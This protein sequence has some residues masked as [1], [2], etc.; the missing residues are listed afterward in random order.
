MSEAIRRQA[1]WRPG[2]YFQRDSD[3]LGVRVVR[4]AI[5]TEND[6]S[7]ITGIVA[8]QA[9]GCSTRVAELLDCQRRYDRNVRFRTVCAL[10]ASMIHDRGS[11]PY[12]K[13]PM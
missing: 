11:A 9:C 3:P 12:H 4:P 8:L 13:E 7:M 1:N 10:Q 6:S 5:I 2:E